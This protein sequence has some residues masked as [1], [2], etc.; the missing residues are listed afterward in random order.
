Y[1]PAPT[2]ESARRISEDLRAAGVRD[3]LMHVIS[4]DAAGV[5]KLRIPAANYLETL[6]LV[7]DGLIGS[8]IGFGAGLVGVGLLKSLEPFGP[9]VPSIVYLATLVAATMFGAW[10]GGLTGIASQNSK[11]AGFQDD[12][13]AGH[14]LILVYALQEQEARVVQMMRTRH[15]EA[16]LAA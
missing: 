14:C 15:P 16:Q 13:Q 6:D 3:S 2:L 5:A 8:A 11:L 12:L 1:Y 10:E 9:N 7:R 4:K